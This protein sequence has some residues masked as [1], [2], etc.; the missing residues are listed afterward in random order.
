MPPDPID[1]LLLRTKQVARL[2]SM[3]P[4]SVR[5]L[6]RRGRLKP[7]TR[8]A[9]GQALFR[10]ADIQAFQQALTAPAPKEGEPQ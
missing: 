5:R 7:Q 1:G 8:T 4:S 3:D 2:L 10:Y 6:V 9:G